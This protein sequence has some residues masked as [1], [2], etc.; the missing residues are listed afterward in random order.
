[1]EWWTFT[2]TLDDGRKLTWEAQGKTSTN[3]IRELAFCWMKRW[4]DAASFRGAEL[5]AIE[6]LGRLDTGVDQPAAVTS[7]LWVVERWPTPVGPTVESTIL[8]CAID[9]SLFFSLDWLP[10]LPDRRTLTM[11]IAAIP[12][13]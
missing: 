1:M 2:L 7:R 5:T 9:D 12:Q 8:V 11:W 13:P 3:A 6:C 4:G 10:N